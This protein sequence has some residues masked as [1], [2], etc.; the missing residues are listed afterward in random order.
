MPVG[1][2]F[3]EILQLPKSMLRGRIEKELEENPVLE[4][5]L[6]DD[7]APDAVG[8]PLAILQLP[9]PVLRDR[10]EKELSDIIVDCSQASEYEVRVPD[11][12]Y[13]PPIISR[14]YAEMQ[15]DPATDPP[16]REYLGRKI[17]EAHRLLEALEWRRAT[18]EQVGMAIFRQQRAFLGHGPGHIAPL[19]AEQVAR[20]IGTPTPTVREAVKNKQVRTPHGVVSLDC[21]IVAPPEPIG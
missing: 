5:Q 7:P 12:E 15:Q 17:K 21:F 2:F 20:E 14:R 4:F 13:M 8:D 1:D 9:I 19:S 16:V 18:L 11:E 3:S 6:S 10:I